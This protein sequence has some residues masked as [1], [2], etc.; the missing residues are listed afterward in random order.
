MKKKEIIDYLSDKLKDD[1]EYI[2]ESV[3]LD[4]A[5]KHLMSFSCGNPNPSKIMVSDIK[6]SV[7]RR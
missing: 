2:T 6:V 3:F 4:K 7:V 5:H 1:V